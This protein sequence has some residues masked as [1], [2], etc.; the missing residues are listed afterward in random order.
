VERLIVADMAPRAYQPSHLEIF[1]ALLGLDLPSFNARPAMEE[2]LA[3]AIPE[4]N[5]RRF[6]LKNLGRD[7]HGKFYWKINLRGLLDNYSQ[8]LEPITLTSPFVKPTLFIRGG[9]S[10]YIYSMDEPLIHEM[11]PAAVIANIPEAGH[12]LHADQPEEFGRLVWDFLQ[13]SN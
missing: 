11:F 5:L 1:E 4:Q 3:S 12:W 8:L 2:A 7:Q 9:K 13:E 6:L 10:D